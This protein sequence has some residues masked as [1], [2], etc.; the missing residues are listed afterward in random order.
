MYGGIQAVGGVL[1][2]PYYRRALEAPSPL[3]GA[4]D[5]ECFEALL[6]GAL[7]AKKTLSAKA[8]L[9]TEQRIPGVGNGVLQDILFSAGVNPRRKMSTLAAGERHT[10]FETLKATLAEMTSKGGR[11]TE[12]DIFGSPGGYLTRLSK[13]SR[14][15]P[16]PV[17]GSPIVKEAYLG[18][19]VYWCPR[20]QPL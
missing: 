16:C 19:A 15:D 13:N 5:E 3:T 8:F 4:F 1:D 10:L 14:T 9:A 17:C 6:D 12:R 20:C 2:N 18:G 11:D 7:A